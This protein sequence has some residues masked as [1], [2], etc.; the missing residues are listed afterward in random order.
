MTKIYT[1]QEILA[2]PM[3]ENDGNA[4]TIGEYFVSLLHTL[5]IEKEGFSGKR[6]FGNSGWE[7]DIETALINADAIWGQIDEDGYIEDVD[8]EAADRIIFS[9]IN[10]LL[11]KDTND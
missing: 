3:P 11:L 8:S 4:S 1:P 7:G 9:T 6:P 2:L 10:N 5:W